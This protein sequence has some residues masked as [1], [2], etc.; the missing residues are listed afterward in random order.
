MLFDY[1]PSWPLVDTKRRGAGASL[2]L[3]FGVSRRHSGGRFFPSRGL[4]WIRRQRS[5]SALSITNTPDGRYH[6]EAH[7]LLTGRGTGAIE[8]ACKP[9]RNQ[10]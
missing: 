1:W 8:V 10:D 5:P 7:G 4:I 3:T 6:F 9:T 2:T